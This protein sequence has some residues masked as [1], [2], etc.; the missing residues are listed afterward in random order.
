MK[1]SSLPNQTIREHA[2]QCGVRLWELADFLGISEATITRRLR[3][4]MGERD[5][6]DYI[7][8]VN[9]IAARCSCW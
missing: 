6:A 3:Y 1:H 9:T 4:E 2:K 5:T 7:Q 8:A